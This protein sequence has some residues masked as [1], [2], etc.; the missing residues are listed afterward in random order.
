[1]NSIYTGQIQDRCSCQS[2]HMFASVLLCT[3]FIEARK[4]GRKGRKEKREE[5]RERQKKKDKERNERK[6]RKEERNLT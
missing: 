1:M 3:M 2:V 5:E 6:G 4:E